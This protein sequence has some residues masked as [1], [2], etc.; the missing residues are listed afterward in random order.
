[1]KLY[2]GREIIVEDEFLVAKGDLIRVIPWEEARRTPWSKD[3]YKGEPTVHS[4]TEI[5]WHEIEQ[6]IGVVQGGKKEGGS[7]VA[8]IHFRGMRRAKYDWYVPI[9][10]LVKI[11]NTTEEYLKK[12]EG[13]E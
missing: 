13:V 11:G 5:R 8:R 4:I 2:L 6:C 9:D 12:L 1:M 10:C 7:Y 3:N